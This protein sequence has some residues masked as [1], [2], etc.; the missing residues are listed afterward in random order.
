M[1]HRVGGP[2]FLWAEILGYEAHYLVGF[3]I[4][5]K[6]PSSNGLDC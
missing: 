3:Y 2:L 4:G 1:E 6:G 5:I